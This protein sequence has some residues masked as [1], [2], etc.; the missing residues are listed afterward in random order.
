M[1]CCEWDFRRIRC[2]G[3][4][5]TDFDRLPSWR[6]EEFPHLRV[7]ACDSCKIYLVT[8]DVSRDKDAVALVE[9]LAALPLHFWVAKQGYR[10]LELNLLGV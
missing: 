6:A 9:D 8:A 1:C 10:R 7:D 5:E 4:G 3:C 2:P